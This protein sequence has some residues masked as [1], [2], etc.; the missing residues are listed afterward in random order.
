MASEIRAGLPI[1]LSFSFFS[2]S[3]S[4]GATGAGVGAAAGRGLGGGVSV[5]GVGVMASSAC[6]RRV[7]PPFG[8]ARARPGELL[9]GWLPSPRGAV[10]AATSRKQKPAKRKPAKP[11]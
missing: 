4:L 3:S 5:D 6:S 2:V 10:A 1:P 8:A 9:P 7:A 11:P